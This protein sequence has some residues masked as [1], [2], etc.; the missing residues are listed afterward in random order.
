LTKRRGKLLG[1]RDEFYGRFLRKYYCH[2]VPDDIDLGMKF[3]ASQ[4]IALNDNFEEWIKYDH[5]SEIVKIEKALEMW[6]RGYDVVYI[7]LSL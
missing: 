5:L 3:A 1:I 6:R 7:K 4:M 2:Y